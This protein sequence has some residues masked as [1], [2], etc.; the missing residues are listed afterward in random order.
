MFLR[1]CQF[2]FTYLLCDIS[3]FV[4]VH[5]LSHQRQPALKITSKTHQWATNCFQNPSCGKTAIKSYGPLKEVIKTWQNDKSFCRKIGVG[6]MQPFN[7][8]E[9]FPTGMSG[10]N[11]GDSHLPSWSIIF[12]PAGRCY[13]VF[14]LQDKRYF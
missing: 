2:L 4:L 5:Y 13:S 3:P 11:H 14:V 1:T 10:A 8:W 12:S 6:K 9:S 7:Y